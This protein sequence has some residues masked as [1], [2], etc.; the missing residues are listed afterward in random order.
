M[1]TEVGVGSRLSRRASQPL[2]LCSRK[3]A[4][5]RTV[6]SGAFAFFL[7]LFRTAPVAYGGSQARD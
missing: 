7:S 5:T 2:A 4:L 6:S 3:R 1:K